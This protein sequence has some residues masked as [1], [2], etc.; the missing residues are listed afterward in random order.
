MTAVILFLSLENLVKTASTL[1]ILLFIMVNASV[2]VMRE[3]R[4]QNYRPLYRCPLFPWVQLAGIG[5]Y[6]GLIAVLAAKLGPAPL[7]T[8]ACFILVGVL[9]YV[10]YVRPRGTRESALL[11][12]VRGAVAKEIRRGELEEELREIVHERDEIIHDRFDEIVKSCAILDFPRRTSAHEMFVQAAG[13]LASRL[14]IDPKVL[15]EKFR[16]REAESS[17]VLQPGMAIP[18][19]IVEGEKLFDI[20]LVR[21]RDGI[22]FEEVPDPVQ[23]A[24]ILV[25]SPDER[26]Y[27]VRALMAI[28]HIV[29]EPEFTRRWLAAGDAENLRD[30]LLLSGRRRH[31]EA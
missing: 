15:L 12:I 9:W 14:K 2:I 13:L 6:A 3:S 5:L 31:H 18:H 24:F 25:G 30:L 20:V 16:V 7:L 28:A 27:H 8:S 4:I 26:N 11:Y 22:V 17:T 29:Q 10:L 21:C 1:M 19:V 23:T